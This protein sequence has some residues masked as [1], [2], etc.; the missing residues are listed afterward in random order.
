VNS[1]SSQGG[2]KPLSETALLVLLATVQFAHIVDF[3][4]LMPL[5]PQLMRELGIGPARF[6]H[7]VSS[8]TLTAGAVGLLAAPFVDRFDRRKL[9][10]FTFAGFI[11]GT[12]ACALS[13]SAHQLMVAR[14]LCGAFGG[15]SG[16]LVMA[17]ASDVA[18]PER[19]ASAMGIV[20]TAFSA[21]AALGVPFGLYLA[22]AFSWK[23]PFAVLA[24]V[25]ALTWAMLARWLPPVRGHLGA[26]GG[27]SWRRF[28][29]LL[30]DSNA[31]WGLVFMASMVFGHFAIIPFLSPYLVSNAGLPESQ[32]SLVYLAG[33]A[34]TVFTSPLVGRLADRHGRLLTLVALVLVASLVT[35][36]LTHMGPSPLWWILALTSGF[37]VFASGRF[38]PGQ[39]IVSLAVAP[40]RRGAYM[41]LTMCTRDL[42]AG[43][44]SAVGGWIVTRQADGTLAGFN[45]LGWIAVGVSLISLVLATRVRPVEGRT[46]PST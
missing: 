40:E 16:A 9:L 1:E 18:P 8:Y 44:T 23:T 20:M 27:E 4:L 32:L 35:L 28:L 33:G 17:I 37:F 22:H 11:V 2:R 39:A 7:L 30:R 46:P 31:G 26:G 5:G 43:V 14:A 25:A 24:G 19:R 13:T 3:M 6:S 10:L 21:A 34:L 15:V 29:S 12:L 42:A 38:V 45:W 36:T 41:S